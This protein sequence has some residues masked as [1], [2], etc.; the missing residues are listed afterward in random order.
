[1]KHWYF[2]AAVT[3]MAVV[4][5]AAQAQV[6]RP[7]QFFNNCPYP[8]RYTVQIE[9]P[10]YP[11]QQFG[12]FNIGGNVK[13]QNLVG[14]NR[15][16]IQVPEGASIYIYGET[17]SGKKVTWRGNRQIQ[18]SGANYGAM[19]LTPTVS[20]GKFRVG[21][22][23]NSVLNNAGPAP[24]TAYPSRRPHRRTPDVLPPQ[25][26]VGG[27]YRIGQ[28]VL[29]RYQGGQYFF[30]GTVTM[31][32]GGMFTIRYDNGQSEQRPAN[33]IKPYA[34]GV[35]TRLWCTLLSAPNGQAYPG[36]IVQKN[37]DRVLQVAFN[38][39]QI[40]WKTAANCR[41]R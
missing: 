29:A 28:Y 7:L 34:W 13:T 36:R 19:R 38:A 24:Q 12:W 35:G 31:A 30:S 39:G 4:P 37:G 33:Q 27:N 3:A 17:T 26:A 5:S 20:A 41:S 23:C 16:P 8:V 22:N 10:R 6:T 25:S 11:V 2:A 40:E 9:H 15:L 14:S 32:R 21:I 18:R 1:M